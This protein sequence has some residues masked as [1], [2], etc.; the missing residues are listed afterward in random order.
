MSSQVVSITADLG[1]LMADLELLGTQAP[2]VLARALNR[3][4][5]S[6]LT[7]MR[8]AVA[9]DMGVS[10]K[11]ITRVLV[12]TKANASRLGWGITMKGRR[13]PLIE[14]K[15]RGPEPSRGRGRGVSWRY[16]G[17]KMRGPNLFIATVG[18]HPDR[19]GHR[20]VFGRMPGVS[21]LPIKEK[22]G[23][24][25]PHVAEKK[26]PVFEAAANASLE[27]NVLHEIKWASSVQ[28]ALRKLGI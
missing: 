5:G 26:V 13:I 18:S 20:G 6:G 2:V 9:T 25:I 23:P 28:A 14:F 27:K 7:A 3:A 22:F 16:P 15:A 17:A 19:E 10:Q 24:S 11:A 12:T 8:R 1:P 21:R 4:G